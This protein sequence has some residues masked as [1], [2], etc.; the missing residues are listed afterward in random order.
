[1]Y[2]WCVKHPNFSAFERRRVQTLLQNKY[3]PSLSDE[4]KKKKNKPANFIHPEMNVDVS[5]RMK[6]L[7][8]S[9]ATNKMRILLRSVFWWW[10]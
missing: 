10:V 9:N 6:K 8:F 7:E 3:T 4:Y 1:M 2:T 5:Q